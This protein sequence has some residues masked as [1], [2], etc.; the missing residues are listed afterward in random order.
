MHKRSLL[1]E[2]AKDKLVYSPMLDSLLKNGKIQDVLMLSK[3][4]K[5][6]NFLR[7]DSQ[8]LEKL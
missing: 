1:H 2:N 8:P 6:K 3:V 4:R 5:I 7:Q